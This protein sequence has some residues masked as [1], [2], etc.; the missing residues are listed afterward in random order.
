[1]ENE[2]Q[3]QLLAP[4]SQPAP[5]HVR[6][7]K[8]DV[9]RMLD[10]DDDA[11]S[12]RLREY[13]E[14]IDE[15]SVEFVQLAVIA[16]ALRLRSGEVLQHIQ[17]LARM[18]ADAESRAN[19]RARAEKHSSLELESILESIETAIGSAESRITLALSSRA[20][21]VSAASQRSVQEVLEA[22]Q[23]QDELLKRLP[24]ALSER[25]E[26]AVAEA[27]SK[28][29]RSSSLDLLSDRGL[30]ALALAFMAGASIAGG[31]VLAVV[32]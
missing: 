17:Q 31:V 9:I 22:V 10:F 12:K 28:R 14:S 18:I 13:L 11:T 5:Q 1:M 16:G 32:R 24:K 19:P 20:A 6:H 15:R 27:I 25:V 30:V 4:E 3:T 21:A 2:T 29:P 8:A 7:L 23:A 26:Q